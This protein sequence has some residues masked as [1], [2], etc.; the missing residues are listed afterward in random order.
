[1]ILEKYN[2]TKDFINVKATS[3]LIPHTLCVDT[4]ISFTDYTGHL[5]IRGTNMLLQKQIILCIHFI[6]H[7]LISHLLI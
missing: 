1:M 3:R 6:Q 2:Y 4:R 7:L 5:L